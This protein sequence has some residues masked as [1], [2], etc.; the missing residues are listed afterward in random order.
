MVKTAKTAVLKAEKDWNLVFTIK[1]W[2]EYLPR[3]AVTSQDGLVVAKSGRPKS[4]DEK[5]AIT[6]PPPGLQ[7][8]S[9]SDG[10]DVVRPSQVE[11]LYSLWEKEGKAKPPTLRSIKPRQPSIQDGTDLGRLA[12]N[13]PVNPNA[14][15]SSTFYQI[16]HSR[17]KVTKSYN[18]VVRK[19][20]LKF[21]CKEKETEGS[22]TS[23]VKHPFVQA[24]ID[25]DV[26]AK[27]LPAPT[28]L[29]VNKVELTI[30]G[31]TAGRTNS[32]APKNA[33]LAKIEIK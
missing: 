16:N 9:T 6:V 23:G 33:R 24:S 8:A 7:Q 27:N 26:M 21:V 15:H 17:N 20:N 13:E 3:D 10:T 31:P 14:S 25:D 12:N 32:R 29:P 22:R 18:Y 19:S 2:D 4:L 30:D 1:K 5:K 11:F 28:N